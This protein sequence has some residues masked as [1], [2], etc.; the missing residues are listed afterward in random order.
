MIL[1]HEAAG[2]IVS[3]GSEV[4]SSAL[5][6]GQRV[7][8]EAGIYCRDCDRCNEGKYNLCKGMRFASSAKT[9]PHLDGS[10]QKFINWPYWLVHR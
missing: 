3:V 10:L 7:A 5:K 1:G 9:F 6:T 2:V 8:I 4:P